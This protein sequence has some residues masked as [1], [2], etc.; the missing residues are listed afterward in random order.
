MFGDLSPPI[1][2]QTVPPAL[3][4]WSLKHWAAREVPIW[5]GGVCC[6]F[7]DTSDFSTCAE[8]SDR[9]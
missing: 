7:I 4:T 3:G 5:G 1:R 6:C 9:K 2:D 8:L